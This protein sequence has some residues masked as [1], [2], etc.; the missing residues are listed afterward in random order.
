[1]P[2]SWA[3]S[4]L[5]KSNLDVMK[6]VSKAAA[7]FGGHSQPR[8][9]YKFPF[10]YRSNVYSRCGVPTNHKPQGSRHAQCLTNPVPDKPTENNNLEAVP[11]LRLQFT[12]Y[13]LIRA[14][15]YSLR[16][17]EHASDQ[18]HMTIGEEELLALDLLRV[19][20]GIRNALLRAFDVIEQLAV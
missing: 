5:L 20:N 7:K 1:M 6:L 11:L 4:D 9:C 19:D 8:Y 18:R 14:K 2:I 10:G 15:K 17:H 3:D 13:G 16:S 12:T